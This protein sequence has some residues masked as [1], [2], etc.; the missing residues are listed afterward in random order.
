MNPIRVAFKP[1][2]KYSWAHSD[3][4]LDETLGKGHFG[5]V[6][7]GYLIPK[8]MPVA[9]KTCK[10]NLD[11]V[12]EKQKFIEEA[13]IMKTCNHPNVV[14]LIGICKDQDPYYICKSTF[15]MCFLNKQIKIDFL[16]SSFS[17]AIVPCNSI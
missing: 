8:K 2:D 4:R 3:V 7:R 5:E 16:N 11:V 14:K 15:A 17:R 1:G 9:I 12:N 10:P 13:E 6:F